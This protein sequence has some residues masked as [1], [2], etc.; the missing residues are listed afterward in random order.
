MILRCHK[1]RSNFPLRIGECPA[2]SPSGKIVMGSSKP[3]LETRNP[4]VS[5]LWQSTQWK[6]HNWE[7]TFLLYTSY[8]LLHGVSI[9]LKFRHKNLHLCKSVY[10]YVNLSNWIGRWWAKFSVGSISAQVELDGNTW[11]I[12]HSSS[13]DG[14][15]RCMPLNL[16]QG[17]SISN[18]VVAPSQSSRS[19]LPKSKLNLSEVHWRPTKLPSLRSV[20]I[21]FPPVEFR[22]PKLSESEWTVASSSIHL[23]NYLR[24]KI[25]SAFVPV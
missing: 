3:T 18:P 7:E 6:K 16:V 4:P 25:N 5:G 8:K 10:F 11:I 17:N 1:T 13:G 24:M 23:G 14:S 12:D 22:R 2:F 20:H 15:R 19:G 21:D 9:S